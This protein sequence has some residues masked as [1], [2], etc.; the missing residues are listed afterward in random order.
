MRLTFEL[1]GKQI[2]KAKMNIDLYIERAYHRN[3]NK[4]KP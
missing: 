4:F 1:E 3:T 2:L